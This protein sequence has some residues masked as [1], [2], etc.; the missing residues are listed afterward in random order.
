MRSRN[1]RSWQITSTQPANSSSASSSA[2][3]VSTSRSLDGSSSSST[4][5]PGDQRLRQV[6]PAALAAGELADLLLLVGALEVEAAEVGARGHLELADGEDVGAAGDVL[7]HRL[8]ALERVARLVDVGHLHR[9]PD[10]D[11]AAVGLFLAGDHAEQRRLAGAVRADDA[12]DRA[13]RHLEAQVVDQQPV[14]VA[15]ATRSRT[16][17][18]CRRG[19]RRPG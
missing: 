8:V 19:G 7:P 1:Q 5:A 3:S 9:R 2:R 12:D 14:A 15:L 10:R 13:G 4:L 16:R 6:Q 17:S 11:L 18:R